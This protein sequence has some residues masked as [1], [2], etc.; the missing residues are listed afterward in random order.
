MT[1]FQ[2]VDF[3]QI[4]EDMGCLGIRVEKPGEIR[5]ALEKALQADRP[6]VVEI[7]TDP[8]ADPAPP[9]APRW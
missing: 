5:G 4:A 3:A 8:Q 1:R 7:I 6:A 2:G 9:W